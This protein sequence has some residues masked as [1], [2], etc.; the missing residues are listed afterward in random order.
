[1]KINVS[2]GLKPYSLVDRYRCFGGFFYLHCQ[3]KRGSG[4]SETFVTMNQIARPHV[5][6]HRKLNDISC[7]NSLFPWQPSHTRK[8]Q[9]S[10]SDRSRNRLLVQFLN[11]RRKNETF[12]YT[13]LLKILTYF[14]NFIKSEDRGSDP[15]QCGG[16]F[17]KFRWEISNRRDGSPL[18]VLFGS[19][20]LSVRDRT[21]YLSSVT[22]RYLRVPYGDPLSV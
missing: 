21:L 1:M 8:I 7:L 18:A 10:E 20:S 17:R 15:L 6:P 19:R 12:L 16:S 14:F 9:R 5:P 4:F 2:W 22:S 13:S 3:D 11:W